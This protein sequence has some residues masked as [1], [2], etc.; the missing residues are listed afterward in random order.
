M[1]LGLMSAIALALGLG[2]RCVSN[3]SLPRGTA[4]AIARASE[5]FLVKREQLRHTP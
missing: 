4:L 2:G 3:C 1:R 5:S